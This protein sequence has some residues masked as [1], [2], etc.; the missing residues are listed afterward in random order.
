M[1]ISANLSTDSTRITWDIGECDFYLERSNDSINVPDMVVSRS[2]QPS[3]LN[4]SSNSS[5]SAEV[6]QDGRCHSD[7]VSMNDVV[8]NTLDNRSSLIV[9]EDTKVV[10]VERSKSPASIGAAER[11]SQKKLSK[12]KSKDPVHR[13][14]GSF[15]TYESNQA[16][17][18][19]SCEE[20][21]YGNSRQPSSRSCKGKKFKYVPGVTEEAAELYSMHNNSKSWPELA[22]EG[23]L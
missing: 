15:I 16:I 4:E 2:N 11:S 17:Q 9:N 20:D 8:G 22:E 12:S 7:S 19:K 10:N 13:D 21:F 18:Y 23:K 6:V 14:G 3:E 1:S 5:S